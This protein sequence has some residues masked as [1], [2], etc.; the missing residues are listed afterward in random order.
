M[1]FE[2]AIIQVATDLGIDPVKLLSYASEDQE[3]GWDNWKG[4]WH[5]GSLWGVEGRILY[6]LIR[7]YKPALVLELG[8]FQ[9]CS[10]K[11]MLMALVKNRKG[12]LISID[13]YPVP[14]MDRF[15]DSECKRWEII[16]APLEDVETA[17]QADMVFEDLFHTV[18]TTELGLSKALSWGASLIV[19]HDALHEV[20]G[21]D[22][23]L[24]WDRLLPG[25]HTVLPEPANCGLAYWG[26][27]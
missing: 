25:Y 19:S 12:K 23:R 14:I 24:V 20:V 5:I 18:E 27:P 10:S 3:T 2:D 26:K 1:S 13:Q 9:G 8:C 6:A 15:S 21:A 17:F 11:H 22:V 16:N 7:H 4:D